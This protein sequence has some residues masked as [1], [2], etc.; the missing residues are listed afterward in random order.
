MTGGLAAPMKAEFDLLAEWTEHV[1]ADL[2][3]EYAI[4]AACRGSGSPANLAWL[5]EALEVTPD[6]RFL[7]AG[8]GLGGPA[9]WL[10]DRFG[11]TPTLAEPMVRAAAASRRLFR[12][13]TSVAWAQR[14]PFAAG[15][16]DA[17]WCLGVLCTTPGDAR[18][19]VLAELRRV[20]VPNGRL[21]LLVFVQTG[22][23]E[24]PDA[25]AGN[26][27]PRPGEIARRLEAA[28]FYQLQEVDAAALP[29]SPVAWSSRVDRVE[30]ELTARFEHEAAWRQAKNQERLIGHLLDRGEIAARLVEAVAI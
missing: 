2:G 3:T 20:L 10:A 29:S 4:P 18:T 16:F 9:A 15:V 5:A 28:G 1:L 27:F 25:P 21:G 17:A 22:D 24:L 11:V 14:L 8:S 23:H 6:L 12:L 13:P 30:A 26:D 7:D 19:A